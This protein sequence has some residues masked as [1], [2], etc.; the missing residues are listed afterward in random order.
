MMW[1]VGLLLFS[2]QVMSG[3]LW[4]PGLQHARPPCT[5]PSLR[6]CPSSRLL[7][8]W[9]HPSI[10]SSITLF[11]FCLSIFPR[12]R[13]F[14]NELAVC[15]RC[16]SIGTLASA[17]VIPVSIQG[18][19]PLGLTDLISLLSKGLSRVFSNTTIQKASCLLYGPT[20]T[21]VYDYWEDHS[22]DSY[23]LLS[24]K[25]YLCFLIHCLGLSQL[26]F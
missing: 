26:S 10:S 22:L 9:C 16:Q 11:S 1:M 20:L 14:S 18:W 21:S 17:S 6:V 2:R 13:V 25:W 19:F 8:W 3:F 4:P 5:S 15:I 23:G 7:N 12:I 24:A